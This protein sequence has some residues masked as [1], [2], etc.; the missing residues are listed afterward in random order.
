MPYGH[1]PSLVGTPNGYASDADNDDDDDGSSYS[2]AARPARRRKLSDENNSWPG[3]MAGSLQ[4]SAYIGEDQDAFDAPNDMARLKGDI[5]PGMDIFD[6]ATPE[7]RRKRNQKKATSVIVQLQATSEVVTPTEMV[8]DQLGQFK[9]E[10]VISGEP[11]SADDPLRGETTPEPDEP[12]AKKRTTRR[13]PRA[14]LIEK[15]PNGG[16]NLRSSRRAGSHHPPF[17]KNR[18]RYIDGS[19]DLDDDDDGL[20]YAKHRASQRRSGLSIHRDN[21]GPDITFDRPLKMNYLTA[22][23][24]EPYP[25]SQP[26]GMNARSNSGHLNG[27]FR[28]GP[29]IPQPQQFHRG[30]PKASA[31]FRPADVLHQPGRDLSAFGAL[32]N[33]SL[34]NANQ[35]F[36][37]PPINH[38]PFPAFQTQ[39]G[40]SAH[41][42]V[43]TQ[44][45]ANDTSLQMQSWDVFGLGNDPTFDSLD[46]NFNNTAETNGANPLFFE[47]NTGLQDDDDEGT[48]SA[49]A[50]E[51]SP[52]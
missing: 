30:L 34:F 15:D 36:T 11:N 21:T 26:Y 25:G 9:K 5:W 18:A 12:P 13:R 27:Q 14:A 20:T 29:Y 39:F 7:M 8:F 16:R 28:D 32:T 4:G 23:F 19:D 6:S 41:I 49:P 43:S 47:G 44:P 38:T 17:G 35:D 2:Y 22:G 48:I 51:K 1:S 3:S 24:V 52:A 42:P 46:L 45:F 50:S 10:R 31:G 40:P 33:Q 37:A